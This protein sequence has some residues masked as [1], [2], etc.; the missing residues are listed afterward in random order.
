MLQKPEQ[1]TLAV[2]LYYWGSDERTAKWGLFAAGAVLA[3]IPV[4]L[5]F[6]LLQRYIVAGLIA[7]S[8][9]G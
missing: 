3:A 2:G 4:V 6:L 8:V 9:K 1:F 5:L 7:G